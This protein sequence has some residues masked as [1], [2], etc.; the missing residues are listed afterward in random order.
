M[1]VKE[2]VVLD[3]LEIKFTPMSNNTNIEFYFSLDYNVSEITNE[4]NKALRE[5]YWH[6]TIEP[7]GDWTRV[8]IVKHKLK[9]IRANLFD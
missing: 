5:D 4:I 2:V 6:S 1:L 3:Q 8:P 7:I 9:L